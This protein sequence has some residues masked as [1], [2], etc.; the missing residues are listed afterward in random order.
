MGWGKILLNLQAFASIQVI[1]FIAVFVLALLTGP[2]LIPFLTR[3]KFGQIVRD[4]GPQTH[5]KKTGTPTIGGL[6]FLIPLL[7]VSLYLFFSGT[8]PRVLP[9]TLVT[10]GFGIVGFL[11][12]FLKIRK[13]SKDGLYANQKMFG[14]LIVSTVFVFYI[15]M[16]TDVGTA[17]NI[18][19]LPAAV[20]LD[21]KWLYIPF[22]IFV[23]L[24]TTNTVNL[25]D[26]LDGLLAGLTLIVMVFFTVV[27]MTRPEWDYLKVFSS[28]IA[29]GCLGFLV[30]N[31]HPARIFM[32]DTGSLALGG[33]VG[34]ITI[35]MRNP[36]IILIVGA[37]F[38]LEGLS[39]IIQVTSYKTRGKRVFKMAP[40]HHHFELLGW[41]ETKVVYA[42]WAT[43]AVLCIIGLLAV[44]FKPF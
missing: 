43:T 11:D 31:I 8:Y 23:L 12:D 1:I 34:A 32:G 22:T 38:V 16:F 25:A 18:P 36:L 13:K 10:L 26:G 42:F 19:F 37:V 17:I 3:L 9:L 20:V 2:I 29:G 35:M 44:G 15:A 4:D 40:I 39:V 6:I 5:L 33:A 14:L 27:A 21:L 28:M 41:K 30:F 24:S 7:V